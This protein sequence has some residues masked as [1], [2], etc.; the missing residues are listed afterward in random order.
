MKDNLIM[1][2]ILPNSFYIILIALSTGYLTF[3]TTKGGL[4]DNRFSNLWKKLTKRGKLVLLTLLLISIL[5]ILQELNSQM[6]SDRKEA[7]ATQEIIKKDSVLKKERDQ[8]DSI[9]TE[10]IKYGVDSNSKKLFEDVSKA[11]AKQELRLDTVKKTVERIRDSTK[12]VIN[13]LGQIDPVIIIDS[14][15]IVFLKRENSTS[16][17]DI[18]LISYD[19]GSTNFNIRSFV[20]NQY[21]DKTRR[22]SGNVNAIPNKLRISKD[23]AWKIGYHTYD[24]QEINLMFLYL[25]GS[26]TTLD[27]IKSYPVDELYMYDLQK[28]KTSILVL[29]RDEVIKKIPSKDLSF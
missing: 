1:S 16:Y 23:A 9:I 26:Y 25:K 11:F 3:L 22:Y 2:F 13:N 17:F 24:S 14:N 27:G 12:G 4:T 7:E 8:R 20:V 5:L 15:G 10:G 19:A 21:A 6:K 28:H 18:S 29:N